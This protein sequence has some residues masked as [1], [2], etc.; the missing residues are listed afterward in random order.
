MEATRTKAQNSRLHAAIAALK[1]PKS[2][3]EE[4]K[5]QWAHEYSGGRVRSTS[6]L[7]EK[8]MERLLMDL[9][10]SK[11]PSPED[12]ADERMRTKVFAIMRS[13]GW[14]RDG[15]LDY[16]HLS[17]WLLKNTS[18]K[19]PHLRQYSG[20]NLREVVTALERIE[21]SIKRQKK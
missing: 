7:T 3:V 16:E 21:V 20:Q 8:E 14:T 11:A 19:K 17:S 18:L 6:S 2:H 10:R 5:E 4:V 9:N 13:I 15:K 1:I 12:S